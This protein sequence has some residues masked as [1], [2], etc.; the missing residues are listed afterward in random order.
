MTR[1]YLLEYTAD[2]DH[3]DEWH[4]YNYTLIKLGQ[5][6][7]AFPSVERLIDLIEE[8]PVKINSVRGPHRFLHDDESTRRLIII[9]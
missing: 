7:G 4:F 2:E 3:G 5:A 6:V 1:H 9:L 8:L